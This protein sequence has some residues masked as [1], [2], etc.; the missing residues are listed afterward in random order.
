MVAS[1]V[2]TPVI[3]SDPA[4]IATGRAF[5]AVLDTHNTQSREDAVLKSQ[6]RD[7]GSGVLYQVQYAIQPRP[8]AAPLW[9]GTLAV[10]S[11]GQTAGLCAPTARSG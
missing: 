7:T 11:L 5:A 6:L 8:S 10:G 1:S 3:I 4:A 2:P 9:V